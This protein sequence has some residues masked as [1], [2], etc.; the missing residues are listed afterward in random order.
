[1][2]WYSVYES[3]VMYSSFC[4][5]LM[6]EVMKDLVP[7]FSFMSTKYNTTVKWF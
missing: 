2:A 7:K 5:R 3:W 6:D 4:E 1:M